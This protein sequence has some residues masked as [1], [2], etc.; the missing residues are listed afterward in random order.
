[1]IYNF[2]YWLLI[3]VSVYCGYGLKGVAVAT[4]VAAV[5]WFVMVV[6]AA[7]RSWGGISFSGLGS[8]CTRIARKQLSYGIQV[9]AAGVVGF[10]HEPVTKILISRF[11]G[12]PEAGLF[13]IGL[14]ARNQ[15]VGLVTKLISPLYPAI[16]Q[17]SDTNKVRLLV[18]DI[19]QKTFLLAMP[20]AGIVVLCA[21]PAAGIIFHTNIEMI[22]LTAACI[23]AGYLIFSTTV[24]PVYLFL[25]AKGYPSRTIIVQALNVCVNAV[26]LF[27]L[28]PYLRYYSAVA[29][30]VVAIASSFIVL[31]LLQRK[32][33]NSLIFEDARQVLK[34]FLACLTGFGISYVVAGFGVTDVWKLLSGTSVM[35][36]VTTILYRRLALIREEDIVRYLGRNNAASR[37]I[38]WMLVRHAN[39]SNNNLA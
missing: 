19:E 34:M 37:L 10:F 15:V 18:H 36:I 13:D 2:F 39:V 17:I 14:R 20:L 29:A 32:F 12:V 26:V 11:V 3:L 1:M 27:A 6:T 7:L 24:L 22:S 23:V 8:S 28:L 33:L 31:L 16:S 21:K 9:Y 5:I 25:I 38:S 30:N 4:F 35:L